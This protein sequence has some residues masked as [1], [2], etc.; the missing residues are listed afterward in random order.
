MISLESKIEQLAGTGDCGPFGRTER[1]SML[2]PFVLN[3]YPGN[4]IE[5]GAGNGNTTVK[6]LE[7]AKDRV[8]I[9]I[10]P[11]EKGWDSMPASYGEPYPK[12]IFDNATKNF[13]NLI[14]LQMRSDDVQVP[15][16]LKKHGPF[17]FAFLDGLQYL[18]NVLYDRV[19]CRDTDSLLCYRERQAVEY[20]I[21]TG[22]IAHG[23]CD[24]VSHNV[25]FLGG[26]C[27][28]QCKQ[29][30]ETVG[31]KNFDDL[32]KKASGIDYNVKGTDQF[33][34]NGAILPLVAHSVVEHMIEGMPQ[35]F[36]GECFVGPNAVQDIFLPD[37][38]PALKSSDLLMSHMGQAGIIVA[39]VLKFFAEEMTPQN[40]SFYE[41]VEK[42]HPE[43]FYWRMAV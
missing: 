26:L 10:D 13:G 15:F 7:A 23:I 5:I 4:L 33:F 3:R 19:L 12:Q 43:V 11:F 31:V 8:L 35:S 18:D 37:I 28:F 6:M 32:L 34:L 21:S 14:L 2:L 41:E 30:R 40:K 38:K 27:G 17:A 29:F 36:R 42:R 1:I 20:W 24:S 9:E 16:E 25:T 22:R 39:P